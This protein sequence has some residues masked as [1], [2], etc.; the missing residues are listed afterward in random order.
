MVFERL[1]CM[2]DAL[3]MIGEGRYYAHKWTEEM[4]E[5]FPCA[6]GPLRHASGK[7][8]K[9]H[10]C[11]WEMWALLGGMGMGER[12]ARNLARRDIRD[13]CISQIKKARELDIGNWI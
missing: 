12:Q 11:A 6:A 13:T 9:A 7:L 8:K 1:M 3:T 5:Q 10:D 2:T 4:A